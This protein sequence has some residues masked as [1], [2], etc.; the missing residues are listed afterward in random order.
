M[1]IFKKIAEDLN[2]KR[3]IPPSKGG[4]APSPPNTTV[5]RP[6]SPPDEDDIDTPTLVDLD[7][8][9]TAA[10]KA[11]KN[12]NF[13]LRV[14]GFRRVHWARF[15]ARARYMQ[16]PEL[17]EWLRDADPNY[18]ILPLD[19]CPED[20]ADKSGRQILQEAHRQAEEVWAHIEQEVRTNRRAVLLAEAGG[21]YRK[22]TP[23]NKS[24]M[25]KPPTKEEHQSGLAEA[26]LR[27][28]LVER[29]WRDEGIDPAVAVRIVEGS[30]KAAKANIEAAF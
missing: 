19:Y 8:A 23:V 17:N 14:E 3:P 6:A 13:R 25:L 12:E 22:K 11:K 16:H 18:S 7:A 29:L 30:M 21:K 4:V 26:H 10:P 1:S 15:T 2:A 9:D 20:R 28:E 27:K 24:P 5:K